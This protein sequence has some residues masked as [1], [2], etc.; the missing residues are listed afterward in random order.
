LLRAIAAALSGHDRLAASC[1]RELS[2]LFPEVLSDPEEYIRRWVRYDDLVKT[3]LDGLR[4]AGQM[5]ER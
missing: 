4:L 1:F 5:A 2:E 3:I